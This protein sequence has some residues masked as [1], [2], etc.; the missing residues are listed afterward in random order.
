MFVIAVQIDYKRSDFCRLTVRKRNAVK[1][2]LNFTRKL[3]KIGKKFD[4]KIFYMRTR[5]T[6]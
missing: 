6:I 4:C 2:S 1:K 5:K 3:T